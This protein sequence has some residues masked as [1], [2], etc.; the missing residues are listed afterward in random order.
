MLTTHNSIFRK[1]TLGLHALAMSAY[2]FPTIFSGGNTALD[3]LF[4]GIVHTALFSVIFF[5]D[6]RRRTVLC[7]LIMI[8]ITIWCLVLL[9]FGVLFS[10]VLETDISSLTFYVFASI[11]AAPF[12]LANP[13][14][15]K[16]IAGAEIPT[17][18]PTLLG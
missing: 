14:R 10:F 5:R 7:V 9:Y 8:I 17:D 3:W 2:Y 18:G 6:A 4:I 13:R 15:K 12:A 11:L 16:S 1:I